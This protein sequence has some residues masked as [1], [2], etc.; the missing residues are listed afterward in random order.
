MQVASRSAATS[1]VGPV[2]GPTLSLKE[3]V[4]AVVLV[5]SPTKELTLIHVFPADVAQ[6][7]NATE[8]F[9][10]CSYALVIKIYSYS[11]CVWKSNIMND[12]SW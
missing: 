8:L 6:Y 9:Q 2:R 10:F 3:V 7:F 12:K 1:R 4:R 5:G 11:S